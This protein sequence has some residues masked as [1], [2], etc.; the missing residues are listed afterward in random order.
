MSFATK[1]LLEMILKR[2]VGVGKKHFKNRK[3]KKLKGKENENY[4]PEHFGDGGNYPDD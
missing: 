4:H 2:V 1:K 3:Q